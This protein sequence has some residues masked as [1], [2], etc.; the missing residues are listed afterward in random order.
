M[1]TQLAVLFPMCLHVSG[2]NSVLFHNDVETMEQ[3][4]IN[5][6]GRPEI[7]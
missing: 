3:I 6:L 2:I 7:K 5:E 4:R 1:H